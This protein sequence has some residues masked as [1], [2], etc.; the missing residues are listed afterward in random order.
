MFTPFRRAWLDHGWRAPARTGPSTVSWIDP[1]GLA[2]R[3]EIPDDSDGSAA[4]PPAGESA[5]RGR[6]QEF[7]GDELDRYRVDRDRP[8]LDATSRMSP[9]LKFGCVHP[10]TLLHDLVGRS[11]EGAV[12]FRSELCW[13]DC[14]ADVLHHRPDTVRAAYNHR[15]DA[16]RH[17]TGPDAE[18]AFAAWAAGRT[19]FPIVDGGITSN[20]H[21]WQWTAGCGIGAA[22][23][24]RV[25]NPTVQGE[26]FD[27]SGDY[28][29]RWVPEWRG[30]A[31]RQVHRLPGGSPDG[32]PAPLVDH[33]DE[34]REALARYTELTASH[35]RRP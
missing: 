31:G 21:G 18:R 34:R 23:Y 28:V 4:L 17:D 13:R 8:D 1:D 15:F 3:C 32:Y 12:T 29:R 24:F 30:I 19:G 5:A 9:Y 7:L 33:A 27:P 26:K 2:L 14:Y 16:M 25:F 11:D 20:R 22:P 10:R 35:P 6:W